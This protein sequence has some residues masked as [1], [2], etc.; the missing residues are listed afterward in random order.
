MN[1]EVA[2]PLGPG[3]ELT[4]RASREPNQGAWRERDRAVLRGQLTGAGENVD[5]DVDVGPGVS[6]D[7]AGGRQ[8]DDVGVEV[9]FACL[10]LPGRAGRVRVGDDEGAVAQKAGQRGARQLAD[11]DA[12]DSGTVLEVVPAVAAG[13]F[14]LELV[15]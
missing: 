9:A 13:V 14:V 11:L 1:G 8:P 4:R 15:V 7:D 10:E 2:E 12:P 6:A 3:S 5:E